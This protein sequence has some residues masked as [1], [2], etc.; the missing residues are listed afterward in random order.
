MGLKIEK[1][2]GDMGGEGEGAG[3]KVELTIMPY[4]LLTYIYIY[5]HTCEFHKHLFTVHRN[6]HVKHEGLCY[7]YYTAV[8]QNINTYGNGRM[9][10]Y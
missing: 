3:G 9:L 7:F 10:R 6:T 8:N 4:I 1:G 2:V 5:T